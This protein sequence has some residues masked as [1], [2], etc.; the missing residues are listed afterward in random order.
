[1]RRV[2]LALVLA[3]AP[4]A[5]QDASVAAVRGGL[6]ARGRH[7]D[8]RPNG[9]SVTP[10]PPDDPC[11]VGQLGCCR[12]DTI[13]VPDAE[14][15]CVDA[16]LETP[17]AVAPVAPVEPPTAPPRHAPVAVDT[18]P[19]GGAHALAWYV[20]AAVVLVALV[21]WRRANPPAPPGKPLDPYTPAPAPT[22]SAAI[23]LPAQWVKV[24]RVLWKIASASQ[25]ATVGRAQ[26]ESELRGHIARFAGCRPDQI[27]VEPNPESTGYRAWI[28]HE[29]YANV[30]AQNAGIAI[31]TT[32]GEEPAALAR[33]LVE[34]RRRR[35]AWA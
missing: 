35:M 33:L 17:A 29:S 2:A 15:R 20:G 22:P 25:P 18:M 23:D 26:H 31:T 28:G 24:L 4:A 1:M 12:G 9:L 5:A 27:R 3:A 14:S 19:D 16:V 30:H 7:V 32:R 21:V 10:K 8:T 13:A 34:I 11:V 6:V